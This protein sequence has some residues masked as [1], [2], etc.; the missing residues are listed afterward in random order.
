MLN[1]YEMSSR[2]YTARYY[3]C[4]SEKDDDRIRIERKQTCQNEHTFRKFTPPCHSSIPFHSPLSCPRSA[5]YI[6]TPVDPQPQKIWNVAKAQCST[7]QLRS[8]FSVRNTSRCCEVLFDISLSVSLLSLL[9]P[10]SFFKT[11]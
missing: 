9:L 7:P 3:I 11:C 8:P 4:V 1:Q 10:S 6:V 2:Y 5:E